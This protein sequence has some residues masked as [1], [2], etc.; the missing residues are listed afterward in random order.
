MSK[1]VA[2]PG[3]ACGGWR[4]DFIL[5]DVPEDQA[6]GEVTD[7]AVDG[8][9]RMYVLT[10]SP[11][12]VTVFDEH[13]S[14][15][16]IWPEL[17]LRLPHGITIDSSGR[18]FVVD[19][20]RHNVRIFDL[21][22]EESRPPIGSGIP[23]D[24]GVD[25]T[26]P[27]YYEKYCSII[28]GAPPFNNPTKVAVAADSTIFVTDG[29]GN[30]RVHAFDMHGRHLHSWGEPGSRP[31][32]FRLPHGLCVARD[33]RVL[34]ADREN[35]RIQTFDQRGTLLEVWPD[36]QRPASIVE[37]ADSLF[38]VGE[39]AWR[40]GDVSFAHGRCSHFKAAGLQFV[41]AHGKAL[42]RVTGAHQTGQ[43]DPT[44]HAPHGLVRNH[45]GHALVAQ[46]RP[47]GESRSS[48]GELPVIARLRND[49]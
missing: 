14:R 2:E 37:M 17:D 1:V 25:W 39:L 44:V 32:E 19:Q 3:A 18:V 40:P 33:T 11:A 35:D 4:L 34:V 38:L 26:A 5:L 47:R 13:G 41:D 28:H 7:V 15:C 30:A 22:G 45:R 49:W 8:E 23:S 6:W 43:A 9:D 31:G 10:R 12:R 16:F 46:L 24:T 36:I 20:G 29:Y 42:G 48:A 21:K 27:S